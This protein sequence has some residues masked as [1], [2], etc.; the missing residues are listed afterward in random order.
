M[1]AKDIDNGLDV[2]VNDDVNNVNDKGA[3]GDNNSG[4]QGGDEAKDGLDQFPNEAHDFDHKRKNAF[5][6]SSANES[7]ET[8]EEEEDNLINRSSQRA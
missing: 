5:L 4:Q 1:N 7:E 2:Q 8:V 6:D 3:E